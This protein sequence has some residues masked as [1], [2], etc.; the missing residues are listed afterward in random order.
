MPMLGLGQFK[1][2]Q[3]NFMDRV[4]VGGGGGFG[5]GTDYLNI[6]VSPLIGYK[7]TEQFSAGLI[8]SYQYVKF[9]DAS[10]SNFGGGPFA[11]YNVTEKFFGYTEYE[12]LNFAI[13]PQGG[14]QE[15]RG[16]TSWF[17]GIGYTEPIS[18]ALS[19]NVSALY[20]ILH[21]DGLDS[22]YSSPLVFRVGFIAGL[23]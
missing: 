21:G 12:Y 1:Q 19:F 5:G 17:V 14:S 6:S 11:R 20:N 15:R 8:T 3:G 2:Q 16:Y 7:I 10:F 22:P 18:R 13:S 9:G 23:F 4:Y